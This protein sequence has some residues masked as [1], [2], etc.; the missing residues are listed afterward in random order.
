MMICVM[1]SY[2]CSMSTMYVI[3]CYVVLFGRNKNILKN[4]KVPVLVLDHYQRG[5]FRGVN[6]TS[7]TPDS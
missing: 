4:K 7:I 6:H 3:D 1:N 2:L 5:S